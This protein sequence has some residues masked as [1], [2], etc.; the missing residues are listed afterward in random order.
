MQI[1]DIF[2]V[3]N[4]QD[5]VIGQERR[6]IVHAKH[7]LHRASY[8][9]IFNQKGEVL[10]QK[11]SATK[12]TFPNC[13]TSSV[14]G[15]VD[16]GETY[17]EA[18]HRELGEEVGI[19]TKPP[20]REVAYEKAA[21]VTDYEFLRLYRVDLEGPFKILEDEVSE[22]RW[23]DPR[24]LTSQ[25]NETPDLFTISFRFLWLKYADKLIEA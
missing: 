24:E 22:V 7:L 2:D 18:A 23:L 6:S 9:M 14:S 16:A 12:D 25:M 11:R 21:P 15:H 4:E 20:L 5:E 17:L 10:I 3:V 19:W 1:E 8:V 13:W